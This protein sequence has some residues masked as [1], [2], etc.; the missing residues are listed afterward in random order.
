MFPG[1][2]HSLLSPGH[3][4]DTTRSL[5]KWTSVMIWVFV[6]LFVL[7]ARIIGEGETPVEKMLLSDGPCT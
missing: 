6:Y 3:F 1:L 5:L 4:P 7:Q 2:S